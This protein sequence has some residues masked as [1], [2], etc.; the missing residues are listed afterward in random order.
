LP[1]HYEVSIVRKDG[2]IRHLHVVRKQILWGGQPQY[3]TIY[4]DITERKQAEEA[5]KNSEEFLNNIIEKTPNA[6]WVS[7]KKGTIIRMN[8]ALRDLLRVNDEEIIGKYN[9]LKDTQVIEQGYLPLVKSVFVKG[10]TVSFTLDY[11]T[12]KEQ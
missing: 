11:H 4:Q 12:A 6:L 8:Q 3:Q 7:D 5:L 1:D 10:N 2:M 9:V